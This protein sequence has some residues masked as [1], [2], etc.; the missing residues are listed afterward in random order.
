MKFK[1]LTGSEKRITHAKK[2]LIKWDQKSRSKIQF[3]TKQ[4][5]KEY[6]SSHVVF[7]EFP[8]AGTRLKFD[9]YNANKR[10]AVEVHGAQHTK[11]VQFFHGRKSNFVK[12]LRRDQHL[13]CLPLHF[14]VTCRGAPVEHMLPCMPCSTGCQNRNLYKEHYQ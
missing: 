10:T 6:W 9:F 4:F 12:Q 1:T 7:E 14:G 3:K 2:Y 8:V 5:L 13:A 11:F